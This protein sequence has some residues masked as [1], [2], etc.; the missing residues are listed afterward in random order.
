MQLFIVVEKYILNFLRD[1][2]FNFKS[3]KTFE[4]SNVS[5][6]QNMLQ[7]EHPFM[8]SRFGANEFSFFCYFYYT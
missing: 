4:I 6:I 1:K 8:I 7:S 2:I 5:I 3:N